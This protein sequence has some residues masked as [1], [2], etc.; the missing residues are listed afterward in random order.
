[1]KPTG[2]DFRLDPLV[3]LF[4]GGSVPTFLEIVLLVESYTYLQ[5]ST[6]NQTLFN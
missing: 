2:I 6:P 3:L 1:M 5:A 4:E